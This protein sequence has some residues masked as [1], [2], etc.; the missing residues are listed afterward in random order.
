MA[1][2]G[3]GD[4]YEKA[5]DDIKF[6][7]AAQARL[8][9]RYTL[10]NKAVPAHLA[11]DVRR[12]TEGFHHHAHMSPGQQNPNAKLVEDLGLTDYLS[13][14]LAVAGTVD[15]CVQRIREVGK[16]GVHRLW[17]SVGYT[18]EDPQTR[19]LQQIMA[20]LADGVG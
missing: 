8:M 11:D 14:R 7:L 10:E 6:S 18:P 4:S 1:V 3:I 13:E 9:F 2:L 17:F 20:K 12:L 16:Y 19:G 15:Q 5:V